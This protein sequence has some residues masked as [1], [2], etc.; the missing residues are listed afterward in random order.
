MSTSARNKTKEEDEATKK[1][2]REEKLRKLRESFSLYSFVDPSKPW[3]LVEEG[4]LLGF[5]DW[6]PKDLRWG[7]WNPV[8]ILYLVVVYLGFAYVG[9]VMSNSKPWWPELVK[10]DSAQQQTFWNA[11]EELEYPAVG[12]LPWYYDI[13]AGLWMVYICY[14]II[15]ESPVGFG[16]W[17]TYT[18]QSWTVNLV[19]H[20]LCA[21]APMS[22][23][24]KALA[25][26]TRFP[27][28][29]SATITFCVWNFVLFPFVLLFVMKTE[30]AK[31]TFWNFCTS[32][33]LLNL[34]ALNIVVCILN[35]G[36]FSSPR[37]QLEWMD[38]YFAAGSVLV[39]MSFYF[40]ILDRMGVHLYPLFS[41]RAKSYIVFASWTAML[42]VY[43]LTFAAW[44][45]FVAPMEQGSSP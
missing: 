19:R 35:C 32:F 9:Y 4:S 27:A 2:Q 13:V 21:L 7:P 30:E 41:P 15:F 39:Y 1:A 6:I 45:K 10:K 11:F 12:S 34:H 29:C 17:V 40:G 43:L 38:F 33:R 25:E 3:V 24:A 14:T 20:F 37:R 5:F 31:R 23:V 36:P 8:A 28:A 16:A 42:L 44:Q 22:P 26:M 18:V